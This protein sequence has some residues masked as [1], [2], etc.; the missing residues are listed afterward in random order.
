[1]VSFKKGFT[2]NWFDTSAFILMGLM[3]WQ[4]AINLPVSM[5]SIT[6]NSNTYLNDVLNGGKVAHWNVTRMPLKVYIA[7]GTKAGNWSMA[8]KKLVYKAMLT[9]SGVTNQ[10][11]KFIE[12]L[13]QESADIVIK[14]ESRLDHSRLGVSP[15]RSINN[16]I[17]YSDVVVATHNPNTG[18]ALDSA[19]LQMTIMHELGHALGL[20]G[21]SPNPQDLMYWSTSP[22]QTG[23]LTQTDINTINAL[24]NLKP[25]I[26][27]GVNG[28]AS[29]GETRWGAVYYLQAHKLLNAKKY[30]QAYQTSVEGLKKAPTNPLLLY[31]AGESSFRMGKEAEAAKYFQ[32]CLQYDADNASA[33]YNLAVILVNTADKRRQSVGV[34]DATTLSLYK[35]AINH[36]AYTNGLKDAPPDTGAFLQKVKSAYTR[37]KTHVASGS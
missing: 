16:S 27:N 37:L 11:I 33:R 17:L 1:M 35:L 30:E 9:W 29:A 5:A 6:P 15:F 31:V 32:K 23:E 20:A 21:H 22:Q 19:E 3:A 4:I 10:K 12:T 24:Y 7:N 8:T 36:L 14:W 2:L 25:D 18:E 28:E 13:S 26:T 34:V